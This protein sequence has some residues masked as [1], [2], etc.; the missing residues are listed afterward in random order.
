MATGQPGSVPGGA[1][2]AIRPSSTSTGA[3]AFTVERDI[4]PRLP[5]ALLV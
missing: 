2:A 4:L 5:V 1:T 3:H